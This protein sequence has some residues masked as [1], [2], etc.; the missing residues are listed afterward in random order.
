MCHHRLTVRSALSAPCAR[1]NHG[2]QSAEMGSVTGSELRG[3][4]SDPHREPAPS[5]RPG[6]RRPVTCLPNNRE[7]SAADDIRGRHSRL[8]NTHPR[9]FRPRCNCLAATWLINATRRARLISRSIDTVFI[10][11]EQ[12]MIH[13]CNKIKSN[14]SSSTVIYTL[15]R[16]MY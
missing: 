16:C 8:S 4:S 13:I 1:L 11:I 10:F 14:V 15:S 12:L 2:R 5:D 7:G 3:M 9:P 6:A